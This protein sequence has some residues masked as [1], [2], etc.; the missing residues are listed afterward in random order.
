MV[1]HPLLST[2][3]AAPRIRQPHVSRKRLVDGLQNGL[4]DGKYFLRKLTVVSAPAGYGKTTLLGEWIA[5]SR[6]SSAW[7]TLDETDD[8]PVRFWRYVI[9]AL[10]K[11]KSG[12]WARPGEVLCGATAEEPDHDFAVLLLDALSALR[13]PLILV[14]DDFHLVTESRI[15]S[16]ITLMIEHLPP[17]VH[18]VLAGRTDPPLPLARWRAQGI[19]A[20]IRQDMLRFIRSETVELLSISGMQLTCEEQEQLDEHTEGWVTG[21]YLA[22]LSMVGRPD[23]SAFMQELGMGNRHILDYLSED[24]LSRQPSNLRRFLLR[25]S[26]LNRMCAQLCEAVTGEPGGQ[27]TL[28]MIERTNLFLIPIDGE[29]NWYRYHR[30][31]SELLRRQ[32]AAETP[33]L[34]PELHRRAGIWFQEQDP[35]ASLEHF[36][37]A[38]DFDGAADL[39]DRT[40]ETFWGRGEK[41]TLTRWLDA[42]PS[43]VIGQRPRLLILRAA[44]Y[45]LVGQIADASHCVRRAEGKLDG[46][47][48]QDQDVV[49][50]MVAVLKANLETYRG[51]TV[52]SGEHSR[53]ALAVLPESM[54]HWRGNAAVIAGDAASLAGDLVDAENYYREAMV[55]GNTAGDRFLELFAGAKLANHFRY[56]GRLRATA[57]LAAGLLSGIEHTG[58]ERSSRAAAL[59]AILGEAYCE[60][61][62]LANAWRHALLARDLSEGDD[63]AA[64]MGWCMLTQARV[65]FAKEDR[66][67]AKDVLNEI[68]LKG[69][70][71]AFPVWVLSGLKAW[72]VNLTAAFPGE[73]EEKAAESALAGR[74]EG[75][76]QFHYFNEPL[77]LAQS[78]LQIRCGSASEA[79]PTLNRVKMAARTTGRFGSVLH[80]EALSALAHAQMGD[81]SSALECLGRA[82]VLAEPEGFVRVFLDLGDPMESLLCRA[83]AGGGRKSY[84]KTLLE[85]RRG[86]SQISGGGPAEPLSVRE[87]EVL[88]LIR[89]GLTNDEIAQ[90]L[91]LSLPTVKWHISNIYGKLGV[92]SRTQALAAAQKDGLVG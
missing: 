37:M 56:R 64:V 84:A 11:V 91:Y 80:C 23:R 35:T 27:L 54:A 62:D 38:C 47:C 50:G 49:K 44:A 16:A 52:S 79:L 57:S 26:V 85:F 3:L 90:R 89:E 78:W 53:M 72:K 41:N 30:L 18:L 71:R 87:R 65:L 13:E 32:L 55:A 74:P 92:R 24:V 86:T 70:S 28:E 60:R 77:H 4:I 15:L 25:T 21:L 42:L 61:N 29:R 1:T 7:L 36:L 51:E 45:L 34:I 12:I 68:E 76:L 6:V 2:K 8:S 10:E 5:E 14:I 19:L 46:L 88:G 22:T 31:F 17:H 81:V 69:C 59:H 58:F 20:E 43:E 33:H 67:G 83:A 40:V 66:N 82:L 73:T 39:L 48:G 9:G 63:N 75:G